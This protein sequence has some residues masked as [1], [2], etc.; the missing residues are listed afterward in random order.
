MNLCMLC[1]MAGALQFLKYRDIFFQE[2]ISDTVISDGDPQTRWLLL[3]PS[4]QRNKAVTDYY[5]DYV[6]QVKVQNNRQI[7]LLP[8]TPEPVVA[9]CE[10][11]TDDY[12]SITNNNLQ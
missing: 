4:W 11:K 12:F 8:F 5:K 6:E 2:K 1:S 10:T 7:P 3:E 9:D